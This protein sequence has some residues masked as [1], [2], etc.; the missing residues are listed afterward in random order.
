MRL[1]RYKKGKFYAYLHFCGTFRLWQCS[2]CFWHANP[3]ALAFANLCRSVCGT[4]C[5]LFLGALVF[6]YFSAQDENVVLLVERWESEAHLRVHLTQPHMAALRKI[7]DAFIETTR[8]VRA[9]EE[10]Y[11][12]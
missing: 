8:L 2:A 10:D 4:E 12:L 9:Q 6:Y 7:K 11:A 1:P 3:L 5:I